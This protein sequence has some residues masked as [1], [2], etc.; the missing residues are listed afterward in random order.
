MDVRVTYHVYEARTA[1]RL[2]LRN[3]A[4]LSGV[5]RSEISNIENN[6]TD[7]TVRTLCLLSR[8]LDVPPEKLY[9]FE[10]IS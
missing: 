4:T 7:P 3:L 1:K 6:L 8:A 9:S 2:S 5:S 10:V